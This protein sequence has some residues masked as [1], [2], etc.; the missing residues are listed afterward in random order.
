MTMSRF[1][2]SDNDFRLRC[3]A[4][5]LILEKRTQTA[6]TNFLAQYKANKGQKAL[7][8]LETFIDAEKASFRE[9]CALQSLPPIWK[10]F[11]YYYAQSYRS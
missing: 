5:W 6:L 8:E 11:C 4:R 10:N 7:Q 2:K 3:F 9:W 1:Q